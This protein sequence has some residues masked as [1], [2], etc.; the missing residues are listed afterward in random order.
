MS[1]KM[2]MCSI[3]RDEEENVVDMMRSVEGLIDYYCVGFDRATTDKTEEI[4]RDYLKDR[5]AFFYHFRWKNDFS[6]AR[7]LCLDMAWGEFPDAEY[8]FLGD[9][10]DVLHPMS[11]PLIQ[12]WKENPHPNY[13]VLN[14]FV[15][16]DP[17]PYGV[18][19]LF[20]PRCTILAADPKIRFKF[21]SHNVIEAGSDEQLLIRDFVIIH[22]QK[23]RKRAY[24]EKQRLEMNIENL[25]E[26]AR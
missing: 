4:V 9:G 13:L 10:D 6:W 24:R 16:L 14:A 25:Q 3:L 7:N 5:E 22:R 8:V 26:Q 15:Y 23:P 17:D 1:A 12:G 21:S 19:M 2:V 11:R 18:P 20:Y